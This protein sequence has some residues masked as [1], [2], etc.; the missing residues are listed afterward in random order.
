[1]KEIE[2][3]IA[4]KIF[5]AWRKYTE[6]FGQTPHGTKKQIEAMLCFGVNETIDQYV[7]DRESIAFTHGMLSS[8]AHK[9]DVIKS[10]IDTAERIKGNCESE[11]ERIWI[12][13]YIAEL[14]KGLNNVK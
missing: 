12:M 10:R 11:P 9:Q 1:M 6:L 5:I 4:D 14:K 3:K 7:K 13:H 2:R 8:E